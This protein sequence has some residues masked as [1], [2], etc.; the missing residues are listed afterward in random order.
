MISKKEWF[1]FRD[2]IEQA[3]ILTPETYKDFDEFQKGF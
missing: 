2:K 1:K 3:H